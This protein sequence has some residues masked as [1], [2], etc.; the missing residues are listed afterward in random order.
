M[1]KPEE[2]T[3]RE[4]MEELV[5]QQTKDTK[6]QRITAIV[7]TLLLVILGVICLVLVP[8][9]VTT[10]N[11]ANEVLEEAQTTLTNVNTLVED[12]TE[13][14]TESTRKISEIDID[15][16]NQ[17]IQDLSDIISPLADLFR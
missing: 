9:A 5:R 12:N 7:N 15:T 11:Q 10:L 1:K 4:L 3:D 14:V 2:M 17:S 13:Y 6:N 16:L 8:R